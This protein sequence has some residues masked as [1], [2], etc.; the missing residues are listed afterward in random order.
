M[1]KPY[2]FLYYS[3]VA[4]HDDQKFGEYTIPASTIFYET[5]LVFAFVNLKPVLPGR[6]IEGFVANDSMN[7]LDIL[8]SPKRDVERLADLTDVETAD[9]FNSAK[10]LQK[11]LESYYQTCSATICVQV[12]MSVE[13]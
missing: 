11:F 6:E 7:V 2:L 13:S 1:S 5:D 9:L 4:E 3:L 12:S 8:I 10:K